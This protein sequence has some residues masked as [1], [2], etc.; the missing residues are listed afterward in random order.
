MISNEEYAQKM[1]DKSLKT[2]YANKDS[3][4]Y[5]KL[6]AAYNKKVREKVQMLRATLRKLYE[7]NPSLF[8]KDE[9]MLAFG[10]KDQ[11]NYN[12]NAPKKLEQLLKIIN[13]RQQDEKRTSKN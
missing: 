13:E 1:R 8:Y 11:K 10:F 5:K 6:R 7:Q 2:Y 4:E 3:L 12:C 9:I